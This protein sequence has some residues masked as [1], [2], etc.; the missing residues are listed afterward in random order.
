MKSEIRI[1]KFESLS[2]HVSDFQLS[3]EFKLDVRIELKAISGFDIRISH[4]S[5]NVVVLH[6]QHV[7]R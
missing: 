6:C 1:S 4:F 2:C 5:F 3:D 7:V